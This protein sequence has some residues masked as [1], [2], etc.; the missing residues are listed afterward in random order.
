MGIK[1]GQHFS[2]EVVRVA[3]SFQRD[4]VSMQTQ[5]RRREKSEIRILSAVSPSRLPVV[6]GGDKEGSH[7]EGIS[8]KGVE[9]SSEGSQ[10]QKGSKAVSS[11]LHPAV[12]VLNGKRSFLQAAQK[13][14]FTKQKFQ[15]VEVDGK[16]K[17]VVPREVFEDVKPLWEDFVVGKFVN[18]KAPHV[19]KIHMIVNKIW[20]LGDKTSLIDVFAVNEFT[21][22][23]RVR[24]E[25]MQHRVLNRGMWNIADLPMII[26][27]W[28]PFTE[29]AQPVMKSIPLWVT[30]KNVP[31]TLFTEKGFEFLASAVGEPI[32]LHSNT[33][34]CVSFDKAQIMVNADLTKELPRE[35]IVSGEEEGELETVVLYSYPQLPPRCSN[36][37]QWGHLRT[38]CL[39]PGVSPPL[40]TQSVSPAI[41]TTEPQSS[42]SPPALASEISQVVPSALVSESLIVVPPVL[43]SGSSLV[44]TQSVTNQDSGEVNLTD[45]WITPKSAG[46]ISPSKR[47]EKSELGA[48]SLLK[49]S[50]SVLGEAEDATQANE[51]VHEEVAQQK[52]GV[53]AQQSAEEVPKAPLQHSGVVSTQSAQPEVQIR[54]YLHRGTKTAKKN[55]STLHTQ[56]SRTNPGDQMKLSDQTEEFFCSF[57][58]A[59]NTVEARKILWEELRAH[60]DSPIIQNKPWLVLGDF[61]ET[62]DMAEHSKVDTNPIIFAGMRDFQAVVNYCSL[63][64]MSFHGPLFTWCNKRDAD[65][66][67]KK[68][69]RVMINDA[70]MRSFP[71]AYSVFSAGGCSDHLHS[72]V[73]LQGDVVSQAR[74]HKPF[75]FVNLM[76]EMEEFRPLVASY[77]QDT[78]PLFL[79]TSTLFRFS[80]K[81]KSLKPALRSLAKTRLGNLVRKTKRGF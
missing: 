42:D 30:L 64:D 48:G 24:S 1:T 13:R 63:S 21:V 12:G 37:Q 4:S 62:L 15:V 16:E 75:K 5:N 18:A 66:I 38:T 46:R 54:T 53:S 35:Y 45:V 7:G 34:A 17:V 69:D 77:W 36:C 58:Y 55:N 59:L 6:G 3:A 79:S 43:G 27:K 8:E 33:E 61:N 10:V 25:G 28:S 20:R 23:F 26:S 40:Q 56:S 29:E 81:L 60:H 32:R 76:T 67:H 2:I 44:E 31:P 51:K 41:G 39:S 11:S 65:L 9:V 52:A 14:M 49:N 22:K 80:K 19:G 70:W 47:Q 74:R 72:R 71:Q 73:M 57:V 68:L 50:Y 78:Q